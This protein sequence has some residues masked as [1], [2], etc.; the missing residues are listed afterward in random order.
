MCLRATVMC[1]KMKIN[2]NCVVSLRDVAGSVGT[3]HATVRK[4]LYENLNL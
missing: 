2:K 3:S 1:V 4:I